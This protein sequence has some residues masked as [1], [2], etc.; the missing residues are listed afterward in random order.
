M[1]HESLRL[2]WGL[3]L[4]VVLAGCA[5]NGASTPAHSGPSHAKMSNKGLA[6]L[7]LA[8]NYL[9]AGRLDVALDRA[10]RALRLDPQSADV[11]VVLGMIRQQL[12]D[13]ARA[14]EHFDRAVKLAPEAG[15]VLNVRGV[16]LCERNRYDEADALF[17]RAVADP[18]YEA[19]AQS[20][21][22]AG[23]C[24]MLGNRLDRAEVPLRRGLELEPNNPLLLEQMAR[25]QF[26]QG[27]F[28]GARAFFQRREA[29]GEVGAELLDLAV[30]I[31]EGAGDR[32]AAERY[33]ARLR[34]AFPD[35]TPT[36]REGSPQS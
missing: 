5:S 36:A 7:Q 8:Q 1:R 14:G 30:A 35:Y 24:A 11:Q 20:Y 4:A 10:N 32:A 28:M 23:R 33:R 16:W 9:R 3:A 12:N 6:N 26:R 17:T 19:K 13:E 18:F 21:F 2:A 29:Q 31:E 27:N 34:Q 15:H 25:L 22:N